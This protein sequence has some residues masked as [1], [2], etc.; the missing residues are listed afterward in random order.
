MTLLKG[1]EF[2]G[3]DLSLIIF[4]IL[5]T[6]TIAS[7]IWLKTK[8]TFD[9][10]FE[11]MMTDIKRERTE[12]ELKEQEKWAGKIEIENEK[13]VFKYGEEQRVTIQISDIKVIGELTTDADPIATD[14]YL[15]IVRKNNEVIYFP[16]YAV[17][18]HESLEQL[19]K[20]LNHDIVPKLFASI[21][22]DSNVIFSKSIDGE[23][24][25]QLEGL[26][27]KGIW[28][29][30]KLNLGFSPITPVLRSEIIELKN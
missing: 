19:S 25:F 22:F 5:F 14:W 21:N 20:K 13:L 4:S 15:I 6:G 29:K 9:R 26:N 16:A 8:I 10:D 11:E 17:G 3:E 18:L 7:G 28:G 30:I 27:P 24:L 1:E 12:K 2:F 23:K